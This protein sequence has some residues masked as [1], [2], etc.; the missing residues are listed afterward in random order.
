VPKTTLIIDTDPGVDDALAL[1]MALRAPDA[2]V[3]AVCGVAG[4]VGLD[5]AMRNLCTVLDVAGVAPAG[6]RGADRALLG[7]QRDARGFHGGDG[8][9]DAGFGPAPRDVAPEPAAVAIARLVRERPGAVSLLALGPLTNVAL[10]FALDPGVPALLGRLV[11]M[12][13]TIRG[14]GNVTAAA[15][16]NAWADPEAFARVLASG[17]P[18]TLVSWETTLDHRVPWTKWAEWLAGDGRRARFAREITASMGV[19][20]RGRRE[21]GFPIPDPL[22]AAVALAPDCV[23]CA[24][25]RHVAMELGGTVGRGQTVVDERPAAAPPNATIVRGID[26]D[27]VGRLVRAALEDW[28]DPALSRTDP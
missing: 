8:L 7:D 4:N 28:T 14:Q 24:G 11:V 23:T 12:G 2:E 20:L 16:F 27:A 19:R 1:L 25:R 18:L 26:L 9:G 17:A 5:L 22:A 6:H 3:L 21:P 10:A 15:E 13:G